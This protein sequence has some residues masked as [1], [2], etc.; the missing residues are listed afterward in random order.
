MEN[1]ECCSG[2]GSTE[3]KECS[4]EKKDCG[5]EKK[6]CGTAAGGCGSEKKSCGSKKEC[7]F[8]TL[9]KGALVGGIMMFLWFWASWMALPWHKDTV[10]SFKQERPMASVLA[11]LAPTDGV[12]VLPFVTDPKTGAVGPEAVTKPYAFLSIYHE[13]Y[14]TGDMKHQMLLQGLLCLLGGLLLTKFLKKTPEGC[15]PVGCS[16]AL[17]VFVGAFAYLPNLI[18]FHFPVKYSLA[19]MADCIIAITLAG[20][21]ISKLVLRQGKSGCLSG[22]GCGGKCPCCAGGGCSGKCGGKCPCPCCQKSACGDKAGS[23][24]SDKPADSCCGGC[25]G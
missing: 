19:G 6:D 8:G 12:Y 3:K 16:I 23:C 5:T 9:I 14:A 13:G 10:M 7:C 15:C 2:S 4:T 21:F 24:G 22:C 1:E 20:L 25:G 17:G 18:W 11:N